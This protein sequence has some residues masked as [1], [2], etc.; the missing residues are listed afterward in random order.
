MLQVRKMNSVA[1]AILFLASL[2]VVYGAYFVCN[3]DLIE[4]ILSSHSHDDNHHADSPDHNSHSHDHSGSEDEECCDDF[5]GKVIYD[6][7]IL[8]KELQVT[9]SNVQ[10]YQVEHYSIQILNSY[11]QL[12]TL[13]YE[14]DRPPPRQGSI[15]I[16]LQVFLI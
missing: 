7:K 3:S 1:I 8:V 5:T 2:T 12:A 10:R 13:L 14:I 15:L 6:A 9:F 4:H 11:R 16:L